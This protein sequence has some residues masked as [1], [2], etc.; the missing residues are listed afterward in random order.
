LKG[1][2]LASAPGPFALAPDGSS[3][4]PPGSRTQGVYPIVL[5][6]LSATQTPAVAELHRLA[7]HSG[8]AAGCEK[9]AEQVM[10][11]REA[12]KA[13]RVHQRRISQRIDALVDPEHSERDDLEIEA[14]LERDHFDPGYDGDPEGW[15]S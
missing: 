1:P 13:F 2:G 6:D 14:Q 8:P 3:H 9:C 10:R 5:A 15:D 4:L 7:G 12:A 11:Q